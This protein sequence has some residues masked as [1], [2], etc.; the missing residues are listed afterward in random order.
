MHRDSRLSE[1]FRAPYWRFPNQV[2]APPDI[3]DTDLHD[4][5]GTEQ[6]LE[7][8]ITATR[9]EEFRVLVDKNRFVAIEGRPT[10]GAS[11]LAHSVLLAIA[12]L[13]P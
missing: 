12:E 8:Y 2:P 10:A 9:S 7:R 1:A 6:L 4:R 5:S 11:P 3:P 13:G